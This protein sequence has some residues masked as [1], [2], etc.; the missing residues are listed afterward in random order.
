VSNIPK[1]VRAEVMERDGGCV[2]RG[3]AGL[4]CGMGL[5]C[6]HLWLEGQGGPG[7]P[8]NLKI[9]CGVHHEW[10][11]RNVAEARDLDLLRRSGQREPGVTP[12]R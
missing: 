11:H 3:V 9:L 2:A 6:H 8:W 12:P 1:H 7:E 4:R 10:V 5:H